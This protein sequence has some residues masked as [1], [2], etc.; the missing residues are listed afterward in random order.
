LLVENGILDYKKL[1][2]ITSKDNTG[3]VLKSLEEIPP[4]YAK[5]FLGIVLFISIFPAIP[6][7]FKGYEAYQNYRANTELKQ[8]YDLGWTN[9]SSY[10]S[11]DL[12]QSYS[13]QEFP[14]H[15]SGINK[16]E[17]KLMFDAYN[18][19]A[20]S[21]KII[22]DGKFRKKNDFRYFES[23]SIPPMSKTKLSIMVPKN[24]SG[25][26]KYEYEFSF[27]LGDESIHGVTYVYL[28]E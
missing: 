4:N 5:L 15:F 28:P 8:L 11:S 2:K 1:V 12:S 13:N 7:G 19:T 3:R 6:F 10:Y 14:L 26:T 21:L 23:I 25:Q 27:R 16:K 24:I 9:L 20:L 22:I 18:K 17:S